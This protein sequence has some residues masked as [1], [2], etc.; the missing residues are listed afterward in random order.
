MYYNKY[1]TKQDKQDCIN[2][3]PIKQQTDSLTNYYHRTRN[4]QKRDTHMMQ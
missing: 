2:Y 4:Y 3:K 1:A